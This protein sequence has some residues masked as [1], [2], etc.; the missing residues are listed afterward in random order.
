[1]ENIIEKYNAL[2]DK[3]PKHEYGNPEEYLHDDD[4]Y[5]ELLALA[6]AIVGK[7]QSEGIKAVY[8]ENDCSIAIQE[9]KAQLTDEEE[10]KRL[11][12]AMFGE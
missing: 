8:A 6:R 4:P 5:R 1:M 9:L 7:A 10:A 3:L 2:L 11:E 12:K